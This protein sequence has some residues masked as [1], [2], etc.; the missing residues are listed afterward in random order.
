VSAASGRANVPPG[1]CAAPGVCEQLS[2]F[3]KPPPVSSALE[4]KKAALET[5]QMKLF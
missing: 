5:Q 2:D 1:G 3:K 4:E